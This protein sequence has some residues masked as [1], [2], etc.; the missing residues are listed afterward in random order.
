MHILYTNYI[1]PVIEYLTKIDKTDRTEFSD[2]N[3]LL[4]QTLVRLL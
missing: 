2:K 3:S 1:Y 4:S